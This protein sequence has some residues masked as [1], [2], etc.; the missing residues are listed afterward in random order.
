[1]GLGFRNKLKGVGRGLGRPRMSEG[2]AKS[3]HRALFVLFAVCSG[4]LCSMIV[5]FPSVY[6]ALVFAAMLSLATC[7]SF[8]LVALELRDL[9]KE[10]E[11]ARR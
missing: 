4:V 10:L 3:I 6:I 2:V 5:A 1:M 9:V 8:M 11:K 7:W